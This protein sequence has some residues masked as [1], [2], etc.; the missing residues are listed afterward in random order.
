M[1]FVDNNSI[2]NGSTFYRLFDDVAIV[3]TLYQK[4]K[5]ESVQSLRQQKHGYLSMHTHPEHGKGSV[6]SLDSLLKHQ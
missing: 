2:P 1:V 6:S 4:P 5:V 3:K